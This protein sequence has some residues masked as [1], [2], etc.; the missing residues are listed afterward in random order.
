MRT[1]KLAPVLSGALA[2]CLGLAVML[3]AIFK[4]G[5]FFAIRGDYVNQTITRL[6]TAK[7]MLSGGSLP[8]WNWKNF[9]GT[10]YTGAFSTLFSLNSICMLFPARLIPFAATLVLLLRWFVAGVTSFLVIRRFVKKD[11]SAMLGSLMY[12]FSGYAFAALEFSAFFAALAVF[13]LLILAVEMRFCDNKRYLMIPAAALNLLASTYLFIGSSIALLIY[14]IIR[15][16]SQHN[17]KKR[18]AFSLWLDTT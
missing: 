14:S 1:E 7:Y 5:G 18:K 6:I 2:A 9:L 12:C 16:F 8:L 15:F 13:P 17:N 3:P 11:S 4:F 10:A